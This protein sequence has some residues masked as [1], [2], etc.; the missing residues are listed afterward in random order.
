MESDYFNEYG[1]ME[2]GWVSVDGHWYYLNED[3]IMETGWVFVDGH[4]YYMD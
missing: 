4:W 1:V 3:G 2:T